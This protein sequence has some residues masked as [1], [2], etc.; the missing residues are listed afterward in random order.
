MN[1][2]SSSLGVRAAIPAVFVL[3]IACGGATSATEVG[4]RPDAET[5]RAEFVETGVVPA[6]LLVPE[7]GSEPLLPVFEPLLNANS[8]RGRALLAESEGLADYQALVAHFEAQ[9]YRSYCGVASSVTV[10]NALGGDVD[11]DDFFDEEASEVAPMD[12]VLFNGMNLET[13]GALVEA[14]GGRTEVV[15]AG[16]ITVDEFRRRAAENLSTEGDYVLVNYLRSAIGQETWGHISP[17]A[18]YDADTDQLLLLDVAA[19]KYPP[20]WVSTQALYDAMN[21]IDSDGGLPRGVVFVYP[22]D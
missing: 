3:L 2:P 11:Q 14:H 5:M 20:V 22:G 18:A 12:Q 1:R 6:P 15:H 19:H 17:L 16:E 9:Q 13:L 4:V 10:L 21:T 8:T 7:Q